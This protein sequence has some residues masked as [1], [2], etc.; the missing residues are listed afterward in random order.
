[1]GLLQKEL[2]G[3]RECTACGIWFSGSRASCPG[4]SAAAKVVLPP[5]AKPTDKV[6][7]VDD[8]EFTE[9]FQ[10]QG[11]IAHFQ[12]LGN[13]QFAWVTLDDRGTTLFYS[14]GPKVVR[15]VK[16]HDKQIHGFRL[17]ATRNFL[18][19]AKDEEMAIMDARGSDAKEMRKLVVT[20][21]S[22]RPMVATSA[23]YIYRVHG[24][25]LL[26]GKDAD[27]QQG[28]FLE[29]QVASAIEGQTWFR[30]SAVG[31]IVG[32]YRSFNNIKWFVTSKKN[33]QHNLQVQEIPATARFADASVKF[34]DQ[35]GTLLVMRKA[36]YADGTEHVYIDV[37][38]IG[39]GT[40]VRAYVDDDMR[41]IHGRA[42][43]G[44]SV[45]HPTD[46]GLVLEKDSKTMKSF[47]STRAFVGAGDLLFPYADGV[48]V[49][50]GKKI[51]HLR[52]VKK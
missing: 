20:S 31:T 27:L 51:G 10:T 32:F 1:V 6:I 33:G 26:C 35:R 19:A 28:R 50:G 5:T 36:I 44:P 7:A 17:S 40:Q 39:D 2:G 4:C 22:G 46:D 30:V 3:M 41:E 24:Y 34:D 47:P 8:V 45:F 9:W 37:L 18:V 21:F 38:R 23:D 42:L 13:D 43:M 16:V 49:V 29:A 48:L 52:V 25:Q 12:D 11:V 15:R 14:R